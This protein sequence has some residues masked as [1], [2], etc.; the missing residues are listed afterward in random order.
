MF[1][2]NPEMIEAVAR[3]TRVLVELPIGE[4]ADYSSLAAAAG[5]DLL[6]NR[7]VLTRAI[8]DAEE[9]TRGRFAC[10][11]SLGVQRL[12]AEALPGIG[13]Q[14][15]RS[16]HSK[17]SRAWSRLS[18]LAAN[19]IPPETRVKIDMHRSLLGAIAGMTKRSQ[20]G[21][22]ALAPTPPTLPKGAA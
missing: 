4:T 17:A 10:V 20:N 18:G 5:F 22:D 6:A 2:S 7:H 8:E 21:P 12:A 19:D 9:K 13:D 3:V 11:R 14:A 16:I 15:R 1:K